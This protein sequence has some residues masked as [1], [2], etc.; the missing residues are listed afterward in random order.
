MPS[1]KEQR[2]SRGQLVWGLLFAVTTL[3]SLCAAG[4]VFYRYW[5][6]PGGL[7]IQSEEPLA[8]SDPLVPIVYTNILSFIGL[9]LATGL[10]WWRDVRGERVAELEYKHKELDLERERLKFEQERLEM[11]RQHKQ[12]S[13]KEER[14]AELEIQQ[15]E[16]E[17]LRMKI[18]LKRETLDLD[19]QRQELQQKSQV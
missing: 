1:T 10:K 7:S 4:V 16:L 6:A 17:L 2:L 15:R 11:E 18:Q 19:R 3:V 5:T 14:M 12:A 9:A 13:Q 8:L